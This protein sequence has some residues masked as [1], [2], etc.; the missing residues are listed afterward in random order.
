MAV[1][2]QGGDGREPTVLEIA[3]EAVDGD[4]NVNYGD[5]IQNHATTWRLFEL[6][7]NRANKSRHWKKL[8]AEQRDAL[9]TCMFNECQKLSRQSWD[10]SHKDGLADIAGYA[11]NWEIVLDGVYYTPSQRGGES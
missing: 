9:K 10:P 6:C 4:R 11:R 5:P 7:L 3:A 8:T 2:H 1:K